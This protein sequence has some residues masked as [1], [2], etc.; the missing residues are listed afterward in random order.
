MKFV[1]V[2]RVPVCARVSRPGSPVPRCLF[3]GTFPV[4][5]RIDA[6]R[7]T[8]GTALAAR[9]GVLR[10]R[11]AWTHLLWAR[12]SVRGSQRDDEQPSSLRHVEAEHSPRHV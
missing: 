5:Y 12:F 4:L 9:E 3:T 10:V 2:I 7:P 11:C 8:V 6:P 1:C